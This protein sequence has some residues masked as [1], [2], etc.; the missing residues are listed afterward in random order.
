MT[1]DRFFKKA[2]QTADN[3][4]L[5]DLQRQAREKGVSP[6]GTKMD[7]AVRLL[8]EH[9]RT[10]KGPGAVPMTVDGYSRRPQKQ[11]AEQAGRQC[12]T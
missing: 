12:K 11:W 2:K 8:I 10:W 5:V 1:Y 3:T 4:K 6:S 9:A 7:I